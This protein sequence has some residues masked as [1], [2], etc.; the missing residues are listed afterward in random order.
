MT[1][2]IVIPAFNGLPFLQ[3]NLPAVLALKADEVIV[4]D[5]A[6]TDGTGEFIRNTYPQIHLITNSSNRRFP[7][8][9]NT[10]FNSASADVIILLNQD[11]RPDKNLLSAVLPLFADSKVFAV[12]FNEGKYGRA[13]VDFTAGFLQYTSQKSKTIGISFWASG[14][15][16][17]FRKSAWDKLGG[18]DTVFSPGY[19]E[20]LDIGWRAR[21]NGYQILWCPDA[22]VD[23]ARETAFNKAFSQEFLQRI[24]D[25]N[26][27]ICQWKNLDCGNL[28]THLLA[29][30]GRCLKSPGYF[31]PVFM[32]KLHWPGI[33]YYRLSHR[34]L[35]PDST[36]FKHV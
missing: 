21:K 15:S 26:Y 18:F 30:F 2:A 25:R 8:S 33:I 3:S 19:H 16:A 7:K 35:L 4:V 11:V 20:D 29:V 28:M 17:A 12:S 31:I 36:V 27:L 24:K 32:A 5:D 14:G 6:S 9:V 10:G 22:K 1:T 23:H 13:K 34:H